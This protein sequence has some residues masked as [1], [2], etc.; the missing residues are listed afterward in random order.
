MILFALAS[1]ILCLANDKILMG[2]IVLPSTIAQS[3]NSSINIRS[4]HFCEW[5]GT[6]SMVCSIG[7]HLTCMATRVWLWLIVADFIYFLML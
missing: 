1:F 5:H 2:I 3:S 7:Y 6:E 4:L